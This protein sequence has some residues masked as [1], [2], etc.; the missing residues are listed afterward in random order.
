MNSPY[1]SLFYKDH[2]PGSRR[3]AEHI[4][5]MILELTNARS[6]VDVGCGV[7]TWL[8]VYAE[9]SLDDYMGLDGP[10]VDPKQ[11]LISPK[12]FQATNLSQPPALSRRFDLAQSLEVAEHLQDTHAKAF[13][14]FLARLSDVVVFSAAIPFQGGTDHVNEQWPGYWHELFADQGFAF[15]DAFRPRLWPNDS[16]QWWYAQN[17]FLYVKSGSSPTLEKRLESHRGWIYPE[18]IVHPRRIDPK[19]RPPPTIMHLVNAMPA[20]VVDR[21]RRFMGRAAKDSRSHHHAP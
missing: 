4:V 11:L 16:V 3:S 9:K 21:F 14:A 17:M 20:A 7:G 2:A 15:Y 12:Y 8:S 10:W 1:G 18:R 13:V 5:P 19:L 6:V